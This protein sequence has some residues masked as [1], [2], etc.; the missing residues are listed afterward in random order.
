MKALLSLEQLTSK[1]KKL[2]EYDIQKDT[3]IVKSA[4]LSGAADFIAHSIDTNTKTIV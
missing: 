4:A 3:N 2:L 1:A